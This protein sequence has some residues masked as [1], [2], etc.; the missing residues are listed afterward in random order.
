MIPGEPRDLIDQVRQV[1]PSIGELLKQAMQ[2]ADLIDEK[3][4]RK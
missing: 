4:N 3:G 1:S 2:E